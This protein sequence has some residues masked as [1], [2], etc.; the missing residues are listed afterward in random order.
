M[1]AFI[2]DRCGKT[3]ASDYYT[4]ITKREFPTAYMAIDF[5]KVDL[6]PACCAALEKWWKQ[7]DTSVE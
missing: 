2:C 7:C 1:K 4:H 6:C 5:D 3:L